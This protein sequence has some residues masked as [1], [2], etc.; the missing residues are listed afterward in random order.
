MNLSI[1]LYMN[2]M[3]DDKL[4]IIDCIIRKIFKSMV[5]YILHRKVEALSTVRAPKMLLENLLTLPLNSYSNLELQ[6][7]MLQS[8]TLT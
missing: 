5:H 8:K 2:H 1:E 7:H 6:I 3:N 4:V